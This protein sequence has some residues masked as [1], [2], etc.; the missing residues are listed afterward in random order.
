[1]RDSSLRIAPCAAGLSMPA[2]LAWSH[3]RPKKREKEMEFSRE[4]LVM[5][6]SH[7]VRGE[8]SVAQIPHQFKTGVGVWCS[9]GG[10]AA[11]L[12]RLSLVGK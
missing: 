1:M 8:S 10:A 12:F 3:R 6:V 4:E 5:V 7:K 2:S 9:A 11:S